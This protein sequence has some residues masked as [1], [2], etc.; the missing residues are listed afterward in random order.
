MGSPA[1]DDRSETDGMESLIGLGA[2][3]DDG[4]TVARARTSP[5][6]HAAASFRT[7]TAAGA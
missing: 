5:A 1:A 6:S 3:A 2:A 4:T 7:P